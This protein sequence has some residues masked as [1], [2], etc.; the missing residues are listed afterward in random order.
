MKRQLTKY[1]QNFL[2]FDSEFNTI[3]FSEISE[4]ERN[5]IMGV[6]YQLQ[7]RE[8]NIV[9]VDIGE[10]FK[11]INKKLTEAQKSQMLE[12]LGRKFFCTGVMEQYINEQN[13]FVKSITLIFDHFKLEYKDETQTILKRLTARVSKS[14]IDYFNRITKNFTLLDLEVYQTVRSSL[15]KDL[16]KLLSQYRGGKTKDLKYVNVAEYA[17]ELGIDKTKLKNYA[18]ALFNFDKL[19][20]L[21]CYTNSENK[22]FIKELKRVVT[23]LSSPIKTTNIIPL[24][25]LKMYVERSKTGQG[26][27]ASRVIFFFKRNL[28]KNEMEQSK[29][30]AL[31]KITPL[32]VAA[33]QNDVEKVTGEP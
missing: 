2:K 17:E 11:G 15:A 32:E 19:K 5:A 7:N 4:M 26:R 3:P 28:N 8:K 21:M 10:L 9:E 13:H 6:L 33:N 1:R 29:A 31:G 18:C 20:E 14:F 16:F 30:L 25:E 12:L 23:Q 27:K 22:V 24:P